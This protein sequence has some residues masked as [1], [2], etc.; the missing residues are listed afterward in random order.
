MGNAA[1]QNNISKTN[2]SPERNCP[3]Y[4]IWKK[5]FSTEPGEPEDKQVRNVELRKR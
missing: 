2:P 5:E 1:P 4:N 3:E